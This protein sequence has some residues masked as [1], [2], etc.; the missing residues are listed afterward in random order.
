MPI[1]IK[2]LNVLI[3]KEIDQ[4][5]LGDK[6]KQLYDPLYYILSLG[7][8]R[9]RPLLTLMSYELYRDDPQKIIA[10]ALAVEVFHN[11]TLMHDDIMDEAPLR[12]GKM[13]VHEKWNT[14][15]AILSGDVMMIK[16]YDLLLGL[17]KK[18]FKESISMFNLCA[19]QVCEGQQMDMD[20][21]TQAEVSESAYLEMIKLKTAVLLGFSLRLGAYLAGA[22]DSDC[23]SLDQ[24]GTGVGIGFQLKD[25]LLDVYG[26]QEVV[27]KQVGGDIIA[28]K[29][30]YLLIKALE[31]ANKTQKKELTDWMTKKEFDT[32]EKVKAVT[33][34][35]DQLQIRQ[36]TEQEMNN[37]FN[38]A[39]ANLQQVQASKPKIAVLK[40]F[41]ESLINREK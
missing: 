14:N 38:L 3:A 40:R 22:S 6:P 28:N 18:Q 4:L 20:F 31:L 8:K 24:F 35:Y 21:E 10:P 32:S 23:K 33:K 13:T 5:S 7:G 41:S 25:D 27:G 2:K 19:R 37:Q 12:R 9:V 17:K 1:K 39:F 11:F 16:A 29:K 15:V 34:I 26:D 30:T 36:L